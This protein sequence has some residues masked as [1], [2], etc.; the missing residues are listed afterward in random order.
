[1]CVPGAGLTQRCD[2]RFRPHPVSRSAWTRP[3]EAAKERARVAWLYSRASSRKRRRRAFA[4]SRSVLRP[5]PRPRECTARRKPGR[6]ARS[7]AL[8]Q[9]PEPRGPPVMPRR[10]GISH[11]SGWGHCTAGHWR[12]CTGSS[13]TRC[14]GPSAQQANA[15]QLL[16]RAAPHC[17]P[18]WP[19]EAPP[20]RSQAAAGS[21]QRTWGLASQRCGSY[22]RGQWLWP[23]MSRRGLAAARSRGRLVRQTPWR[24][25]R[26]RRLMS[27]RACTSVPREA[28]LRL[29]RRG[30]RRSQGP[31]RASGCA[32][33]RA[34]R[35]AMRQTGRLRSDPWGDGGPWQ[36]A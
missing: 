13:S 10:R 18:G 4:E 16:P 35:L 32:Q 26:G 5:L 11:S 17:P 3:N 31:A 34:T 33:G 23:S 36:H 24:L 25:A 14:T 22:L 30:H 12:G 2:H 19:T 6:T 29:Q 28:G 9:S 21:Q 7:P 27:T 1:M 15:P 20:E 8:R